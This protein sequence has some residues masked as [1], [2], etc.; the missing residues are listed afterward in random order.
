MNTKTWLII[1][2]L[3]SLS[4]SSACQ[5]AETKE[6]PPK[7]VRVK[8]VEKQSTGN[9]VRYSASCALLVSRAERASPCCDVAL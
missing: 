5:K 7:P 6:K 4:L 9:G 3:A 8:A 2:V 1:G